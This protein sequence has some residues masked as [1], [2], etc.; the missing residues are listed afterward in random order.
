MNINSSFTIT[1]TK[2]DKF[3]KLSNFFKNTKI[4]DGKYNLNEWTY[5]FEFD[6][7]IL[8]I[9]CKHIF[10]ITYG[11]MPNM[12]K[13]LFIGNLKHLYHKII[14]LNNNSITINCSNKISIY[15]IELLAKLLTNKELLNKFY[16]HFFQIS[17]NQ[18]NNKTPYFKTHFLYDGTFQVQTSIQ[19]FH[20]FEQAKDLCFVHSIDETTI[21][22][23]NKK[24]YYL[25][26]NSQQNLNSEYLNYK[27]L[28]INN[29]NKSF[30]NTWS[31]FSHLIYN[32]AKYCI[33]FKEIYYDS[34]LPFKKFFTLIL[35]YKYNHYY[36]FISENTER[37]YNILIFKDNDYKRY[38]KNYYKIFYKEYYRPILS[39]FYS[40]NYSFTY[41]QKFVFAKYKYKSQKFRISLNYM[42]NKEKQNWKEKFIQLLEEML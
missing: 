24:I 2:L 3:Y 14:S 39:I 13:A 22:Y 17:T 19:V 26:L 7:C 9:P 4:L 5:K 10:Q 35:E 18:Y 8:L 34:F 32:E 30:S 29:R 37:K 41:L 11:H 31:N 20:N 36:I 1:T 28:N 42:T 25:K 6:N 16:Y 15:S 12:Q 21:P 27:K 40:D 33:S 23:F 38:L